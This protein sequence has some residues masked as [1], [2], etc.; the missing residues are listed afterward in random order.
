[1]QKGVRLGPGYLLDGPGEGSEK[2]SLNAEEVAVA[3]DLYDSGPAAGASFAERGDARSV[4]VPVAI[5]LL[6]FF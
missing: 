3:S 2:A 1:M 4:P 6:S 5:K